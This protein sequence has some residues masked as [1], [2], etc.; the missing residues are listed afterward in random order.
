MLKSI[1]TGTAVFGFTAAAAGY[2]WTAFEFPFALLVPAALGWYFLVRPLWGNV[3]ALEAALVG[4]ATFT[5]V[6]LFAVFLALADGS[7]VALAPWVA[8]VLASGVAGAA[9]GALLGGWRGAWPMAL[10]AGAGMALATVATGVLR[11]VAPAAVDIEGQAQYLYFAMVQGV[12]GALV[13][14]AIGAGV[15]WVR[16][17]GSAFRTPRQMSDR[18]HPA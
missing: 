7:S 9:T 15:V 16:E 18:P 12:V 5:A 11:S 13:G 10:F 14:A 2:V 6:F 3:K 1:L 4:G 17:H 8:A